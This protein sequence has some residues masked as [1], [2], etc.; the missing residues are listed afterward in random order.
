MLSH[1]EQKNSLVNYVFTFL[2][3]FYC[4]AVFWG[5]F[6]G[7]GTNKVFRKQENRKYFKEYWHSVSVPSW[8]IHAWVD[9]SWILTFFHTWEDDITDLPLAEIIFRLR[10]ENILKSDDC[11]IPGVYSIHR[12]N[13]AK[14]WFSQNA[15]FI[16]FFTGRVSIMVKYIIKLVLEF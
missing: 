16:F 1:D 4:D 7:S 12:L 14:I 15:F 8:S 5:E 6:L 11:Y 13:L 3:L 10:N 9:I 2:V